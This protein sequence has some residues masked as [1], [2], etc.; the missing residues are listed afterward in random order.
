M[1]FRTKKQ[2][3]IPRGANLGYYG[4]VTF[5]NVQRL[6]FE[7]YSNAH[8]VEV[9]YNSDKLIRAEVTIGTLS[10]VKTAYLAYLNIKD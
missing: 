6:K 7:S 10:R 5:D 8:Y 2:S 1:A 4:Y 9:L 3:G